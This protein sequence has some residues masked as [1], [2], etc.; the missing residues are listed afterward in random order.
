[1]QIEKYLAR[2]DFHAAL[3]RDVETL[4]NLHLAHM[5]TI[6]FENLDIHLG[7]K[8]VLEEDLLFKKIVERQRGGI[9]YE[10]N[11]L[12]A[13]LLADIGFEVSMVAAEVFREDGTTGPLF[14]HMA[15]L[16]RIGDD[17]YLADVGFGD[18]FS[19][20]L[21]LSDTTDQTQ[22]CRIYRLQRD[23]NA[24]TV[25]AGSSARTDSI[26]PSFKFSTKPRHLS[27]FNEM[28]TYHQTSDQSH[29]TR[30]E[31]CSRAT[32][33]GRI[34]L[35]GTQL[36]ETDNESR[37]VVE[38]TSSEERQHALIKHFGIFL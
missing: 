11:G 30:K 33:S 3:G 5:L 4:K 25:M 38:L 10:L 21:L 14:D 18:S 35:S 17:R 26:K 16:V 12:F 19:V 28:C 1:M 22:G 37:D 15:L 31:V 20:P 32:S 23:A 29:F 24:Y 6:P 13:R 7:R 8:I 2:L 9:C 36:I 34:T 27:D